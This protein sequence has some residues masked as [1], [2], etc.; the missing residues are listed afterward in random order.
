MSPTKSKTEQSMPPK[1]IPA[2]DTTFTAGPISGGV[3]RNEGIEKNGIIA[4]G[5]LKGQK[6]VDDSSLKSYSKS[7][8]K[9]GTASSG[10]PGG[11]YLTNLSDDPVSLS[12]NISSI[13][14]G[15][16][17]AVLKGTEN[18]SSGTP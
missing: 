1:K 6:R 8:F 3:I 7:S 9:R 15:P 17:A 5:M 2:P 11:G 10:I 14:R 18:K 4:G 13:A 16:L 12:G